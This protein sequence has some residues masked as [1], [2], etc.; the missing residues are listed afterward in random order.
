MMLLPSG[1]RVHI[2]LGV[3]DL[4]KGLDGLAMLV[5]EVLEQ[6]PFSGHLIAFRGR[7]ANLIKI[8]FWDGAGL[9]LFTKRLEEGRFPWPC[10]ISSCWQSGRSWT[11]TG[12]FLPGIARA[13][14]AGG[15]R[16][17]PALARWSPPRWWP[18]SPILTLSSPG[19]RW[20]PGSAWCRGRTRPAARS[21]SGISPRL[22]TVICACSWWSELSL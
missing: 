4:R 21:A 18:Q 19:A 11:R 5:Q 1:V 2:A 8:L 22:A 10:A 15:L 17:Y 13:R 20:L 9:C 14:S 7:K 16:R 3:T 12:A 6:D